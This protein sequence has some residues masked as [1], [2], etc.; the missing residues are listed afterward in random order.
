MFKTSETFFRN[1]LHYFKVHFFPGFLF[2]FFLLA[3]GS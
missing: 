1:P 2:L 3:F